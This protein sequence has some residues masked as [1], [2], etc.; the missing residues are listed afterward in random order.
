MGSLRYSLLLHFAKIPLNTRKRSI[1]L[2]KSI[3]AP[4]FY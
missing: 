1:K 2:G 3:S 4:P